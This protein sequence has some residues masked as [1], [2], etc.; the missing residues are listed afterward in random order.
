VSWLA[1]LSLNTDDSGQPEVIRVLRQKDKKCRRMKLNVHSPID[2]AICATQLSRPVDKIVL[3][4][5]KAAYKPR[6]AKI[7][8]K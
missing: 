4:E 6:H 2:P 5:R 8:R 1:G 3:D 7:Q